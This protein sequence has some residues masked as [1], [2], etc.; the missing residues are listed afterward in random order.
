LL[1]AQRKQR[2]SYSPIQGIGAH[3]GGGGGG[4]SAASSSSMEQKLELLFGPRSTAGQGAP[5]LQST[6]SL[7]RARS[8][9]MRKAHRNLS[10]RPQT[11]AGHMRERSAAIGS[12]ATVRSPRHG[13]R[14]AHPQTETN[15]AEHHA[16]GLASGDAREAPVRCQPRPQTAPAS[17]AAGRGWAQGLA[18]AAEEPADAGTADEDVEAAHAAAEAAV[19]GAAR[20]RA[21]A[22]DRGS[23][24]QAD[25]L[26]AVHAHQLRTAA[27]AKVKSA[28]GMQVLFARVASRSE[29]AIF[30]WLIGALFRAWRDHTRRTLVH[31]AK[32]CRLADRWRL[33]HCWT[34]WMASREMERRH[35]VMRQQDVTERESMQ[36]AADMRKLREE[37]AAKLAE[38]QAAASK[39]ANKAQQTEAL[40]RDEVRSLKLRAEQLDSARAAL[41]TARQEL[42]ELADLRTVSDSYRDA[43]AVLL[44]SLGSAV[45]AQLLAL[46]RRDGQVDISASVSKSTQGTLDS[47]E[48]PTHPKDAGQHFDSALEAAK[49]A[50]MTEAADDEGS[51]EGV[52][53]AKA[54]ALAGSPFGAPSRGAV[55]VQEWM[56]YAARARFPQPGTRNNLAA[57]DR[58]A[59]V[60]GGVLGALRAKLARRVTPLPKA[61]DPSIAMQL[62]AT[63][64]K[65]AGGA[66]TRQA[67]SA[68]AKA[69]KKRAV[70]AAT[71]AAGP[72]L[73]RKERSSLALAIVELEGAMMAASALVRG[74]TPVKERAHLLL[75]LAHRWLALPPDLISADELAE[76]PRKGTLGAGGKGLPHDGEPDW[77]FAFQ[78]LLFSTSPCRPG[79]GEGVDGAIGVGGVEDISRSGHGAG[80]GSSGSSTSGSSSSGV[81]AEPARS[82]AE[83]G[84]HVAT[85]GTAAAAAI[86]LRS[87]VASGRA[88]GVEK[89]ARALELAEQLSE[90]QGWANDQ[91]KKM[92]DGQAAYSKAA[93]FAVRRALG[94]LAAL[95]RTQMQRAAAAAS[96]QGQQQEASAGRGASRRARGSITQTR[97]SSIQKGAGRRTSAARASKVPEAPPGAAADLVA[98]ARKG[99]ILGEL[100]ITTHSALDEE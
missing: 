31:R 77:H 17:R 8:I 41:S 25:L 26:Y 68:A 86:E 4:G 66:G 36:V 98:S 48:P 69:A 44:G 2:T 1:I 75:A 34:A 49:A 99:S 9:V 59:I 24:F 3:G 22:A 56:E 95:G 33:K 38:V 79:D 82:T 72:T 85:F 12:V 7:A 60:L 58:Y 100:D 74:R 39:A 80:G 18:S 78:A 43:C 6:K 94:E 84:R 92:G 14:R 81:A 83:L 40:L 51:I 50:V 10:R 15:R 89:A 57:V 23:A 61:L 42:K 13:Q 63:A 37:H 28:N 97:R 21:L 46:W 76:E 73:S 16:G 5:E 53:G 91:S 96:G 54:V 64:A 93:S 67:N 70:A 52:G 19:M 90:L 47:L 87:D 62:A 71:K 55:V 45:R 30:T 20:Q 11:A 65:A 29:T 27:D 88:D 32:A 35:A